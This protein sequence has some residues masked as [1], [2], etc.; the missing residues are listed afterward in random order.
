M[1]WFSLD[2][3]VTLR[4][5][6]CRNNETS[7]II[8]FKPG[9]SWRENLLNGNALEVFFNVSMSICKIGEI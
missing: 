9:Q 2:N 6:H 8:L 3:N 4:A 5:F 1:M 7:I